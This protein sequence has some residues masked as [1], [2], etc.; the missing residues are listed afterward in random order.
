L[1]V[2]SSIDSLQVNPA[3]S[4]G[5]ARIYGAGSTA[6]HRKKLQLWKLELINKG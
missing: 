2:H 6:S 4:L 1:G 5:K 3:Q